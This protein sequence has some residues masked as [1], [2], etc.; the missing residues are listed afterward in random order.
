VEDVW[1]EQLSPVGAEDDDVA[2]GVEII[3]TVCPKSAE[4]LLRSSF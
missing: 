2:N 3:G 4:Y 1:R